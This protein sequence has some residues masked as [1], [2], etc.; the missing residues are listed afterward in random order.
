MF[1][2]KYVRE[3]AAEIRETITRQRRNELLAV[4]DELLEHEAA[5]RT[6]KQEAD[7]LRGERNRISEEINAA[8]KKGGDAA[9]LIAQAKAIPAE[10][11]GIEERMERLHAAELR[12]RLA[13]LPNI[14][15]PAVPYGKDDTEN[16][17]MKAWG[18]RPAFAFPI[19]NH[20]ELCELNG[21]A[22]FDA[23]AQSSGNGF[24]YLTGDLALLNQALIQF[25]IAKLTKK[26]Y[27]Y[28]EPPLMVRKHVLDAAMDSAGFEQ[29]IYRVAEE[30]D[31]PLC[32]IGTAEH[33]ILALHEGKTLA[34]DELPKRYA[35]YSMC[36]R[37]EI[38][39]HGINEK[40]LWRTHQFNKV[41]QFIFS[42]PETTWEL[43]DE[44]M[45]NSEEILQELGLP[46]RIVEICTGDLAL[47]KARSH[48]F[49]VWRPTTESYGEVMSLSNCT[50][51]QAIDLDTRFVR[52][53]GERGPVHTL[54]NTALAT[55]RIMVAIL[56]NFQNED[57]SV[58]VPKPLQPYLGKKRVGR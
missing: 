17:E 35:G 53:N 31:D 32:M 26:G 29:S 36:F 37:Q 33:P 22:E 43:Y 5:W 18:K 49:E 25:A 11:K 27:V 19:R 41:E 55:S 56:E 51:Y 40:G 47:W 28:V 58:N 20:V 13:R 57:G 54:N 6:M 42:L 16:P 8:K 39:S 48:D 44:L 52:K 24:Y 38:G 23:S 3:H 30:S 1:D 45:A 2:A 4:L 50:V 15:H 12:P 9:G 14:M 34:A 10:I 21:W 46:Y 7:R